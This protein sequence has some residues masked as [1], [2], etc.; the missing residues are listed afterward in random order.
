MKKTSF[1]LI[2]LILLFNEGLAQTN[3]FEIKSVPAIPSNLIATGISSSEIHLNWYNVSN[4]TGYYIFKKSDVFYLLIDSTSTNDTNYIDNA[5]MPLEQACYA[6]AAYNPDGASVFSNDAC[7]SSLASI[8]ESKVNK[9][10]GISP[11][12]FT[13]STQ[14]TLNQ[15]YHSIALAIYDIQGKQVA[16]QHYADCDKIQ[17]SRNQLSNGLYFLKLTLDD[18]A[19]ETGKI[20]ISGE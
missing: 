18:K 6:V 12:P 9:E 14:I 17:L 15:I 10:I 4:E 19:V 3:K 2:S 8:D 5:L 11:N 1:V 20:V 13:Q 16:Q 7:S